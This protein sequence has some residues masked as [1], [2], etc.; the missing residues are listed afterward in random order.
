MALTQFAADRRPS[1]TG[2]SGDVFT[3][4][5]SLRESHRVRVRYTSEPIEGGASLADLRVIEQRP[6]QITVVVSAAER[7][8]L[9]RDRDVQAW[10]RL[11]ALAIADPPILFTVTTTLESLERVV[12][13]DV[14]A[15]R[16]AETG[17]ALIADL[18]LRQLVF[19]ATDVAAN[20]AL[21][22]QDL[23]LGEVDLGAQ[24]LGS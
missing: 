10:G 5:T 18:T 2:D 16:T 24:G 20:L 9:E 22:A 12:L 14:G 15:P 3:F 1:L 11:V 8:G 17:N 19:S 21:A 4:D 6:L 7:L 23:A 13:T